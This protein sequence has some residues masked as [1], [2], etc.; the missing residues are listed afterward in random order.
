[1]SAVPAEAIAP[2][3][4]TLRRDAGADPHAELQARVRAWRA[5]V[6]R[7][8]GVGERAVCSDQVLRSLVEDPPQGAAEL[9]E[10]LGVSR[11][12]AERWAVRLL[13]APR[14]DAASSA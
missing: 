1:M 13:S 7:A 12:V 9:A 2:V 4:P 14:F 5:D 3:P 11:S 10:R 8:A 6:A